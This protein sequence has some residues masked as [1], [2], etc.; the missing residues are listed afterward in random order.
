MISKVMSDSH[1][2]DSDEKNKKNDYDIN[3]YYHNEKSGIKYNR[4]RNKRFTFFIGSVLTFIWTALLVLYCLVNRRKNTF[5]VII[6]N[7]E[8]NYN[9]NGYMNI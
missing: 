4:K 3:D 9:S 7:I 8:N 1:K 5:N 2:N 6:N